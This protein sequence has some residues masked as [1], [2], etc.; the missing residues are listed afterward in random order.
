MSQKVAIT[1]VR[2]RG[3]VYLGEVTNPDGARTPSW[4]GDPEKV[5]GWLSDGFRVRFNQHRSKRSRYLTCADRDGSSVVVADP[6]GQKVL[7]P[8]GYAVTDITDKTARH[9]YS[10]L[11]GMPSL[12][13]QAPGEIENT[14]WYGAIRRR[15]TLA[16]KG[17]RPGAMPR[18]RKKHEDQRFVCWFNGGKNAV[19]TKTGT[20]S[21][22]VTISGQNPSGCHAPDGTYRWQIVLR[23]RLSQDIRPYTSVRV[24]WTGRELVFVNNPLPVTGRANNG[25]PGGLDR[26]AAH[27]AADSDGRFYDLPDTTKLDKARKWHQKRMA[28]SRQV[29]LTEHRDFRSSNRYQAHK[30]KA[31]DLSGKIARIRY[32]TAQKIST[33]IVREFDFIGIEDLKLA[34]M[35]R[36]AKGPGAASKRG[37]NRV[38]LASVMG[39]VASMLGYKAKLVGVPFVPVNPAYTSQRCH[40]CGYTAK[41]NRKSQAVFVCQKCGHTDNADTNA[42]LNILRVA[43]EKWAVKQAKVRTLAYAGSK[44]KTDPLTGPTFGSAAP[45]LNRKLPAAA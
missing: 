28:K 33:Q 1:H 14:D 41:E 40:P 21:G 23:V 17:V 5:M 42:A 18:F 2:V 38:I 20:R 11:A 27:L 30:T 44:G 45:A 12:V 37:L 43:L 4:S 7:V 16:A 13:L 15:Q 9:R 26:G 36:K 34:N 25:V 29:A 32:D 8:I 19:F 24:N 39:Q 22:M 3:S 10:F 31:A 6:D 35:T